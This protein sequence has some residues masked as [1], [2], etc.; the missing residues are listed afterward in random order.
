MNVLPSQCGEQG[1][2]LTEQA[3]SPPWG[4]LLPSC[5]NK[6]AGGAASWP[7][8]VDIWTRAGV[9]A[10]GSRPACESCSKPKVPKG[11]QS[12][13][14]G[15]AVTALG[16][17]QG[18]VAHAGQL[19]ASLTKATNGTVWPCAE[20]EGPA[21]TDLRSQS[22]SGPWGQVWFPHNPMHLPRKVDNEERHPSSPP[23]VSFGSLSKQI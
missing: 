4:C 5:W 8:P 2:S 16:R 22:T 17:H 9:G 6:P 10:S 18:Q 20:P 14:Q 7:L 23:H 13:D 3:E 11:T 21:E 19:H 15:F 1:T 12:R